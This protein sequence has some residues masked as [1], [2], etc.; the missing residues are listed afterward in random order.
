MYIA[1]ILNKN[2]EVQYKTFSDI[3]NAIKFAKQKIQEED[4]RVFVSKIVMDITKHHCDN[5]NI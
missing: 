4:K 1:T 5:Y 2:D 3:D